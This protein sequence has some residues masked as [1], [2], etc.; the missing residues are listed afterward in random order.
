MRDEWKK[1]CWRKNEQN[2]DFVLVLFDFLIIERDSVASCIFQTGEGGVIDNKSAM[3]F[4]ISLHNPK[5]KFC[6]I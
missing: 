4:E 6:L 3:T 2:F 1:V 5:V